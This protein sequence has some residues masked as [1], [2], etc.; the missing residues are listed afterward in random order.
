MIAAKQYHRDSQML[1]RLPGPPALATTDSSI[2][3]IRRL[4]PSA[5]NILANPTAIRR[6]IIAVYKR[7]S[8]HPS[9]GMGNAL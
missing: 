6:T 2:K 1:F 8:F 4:S 9:L 7:R 5:I 3:E